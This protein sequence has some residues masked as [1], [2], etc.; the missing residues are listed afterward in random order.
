VLPTAKPNA[1]KL[2]ICLG[3]NRSSTFHMVHLA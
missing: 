1:A 3:V 2:S